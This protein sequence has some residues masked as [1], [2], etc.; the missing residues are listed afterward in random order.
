MNVLYYINGGLI[1]SIIHYSFIHFVSTNNGADEHFGRTFGLGTTGLE[2]LLLAS[3]E[4]HQSD[5]RFRVESAYAR[6]S[7]LGGDIWSVEQVIM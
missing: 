7:F 2:H 4:S 3:S 1:I 6:C 5:R